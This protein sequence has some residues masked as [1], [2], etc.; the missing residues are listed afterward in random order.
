[1]NLP[2]HQKII[3]I[4]CSSSS[5]LRSK[6]TGEALLNLEQALPFTPISSSEKLKEYSK[7]I[8][9]IRTAHVINYLGFAM[10]ELNMII[11]SV[12][13]LKCQPKIFSP[14]SSETNVSCIVCGSGP[15]LDS[16]I[17]EIKLLSSS[18]I[19]IASGSNYQTLLANNI[20]ADFLCLNE[21]AHDTYSDFKKTYDLYGRTKTKL[22]MSSTCPHR[23]TELFDETAI[24]F[25]P[26]L[27]PLSVFSDSPSEVLS[28][29]GPE[30]VNTGVSF[31]CHIG[32]S[33]IALFG[34]DLGSVSH[35]KIRSSNAS[36]MTPRKF[37]SPRG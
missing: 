16:S 30:A 22:V 24:F 12:D 1:M 4:R 27:T 29:E 31:A 6:I 34:V 21:R 35:E 8:H 28:F 33:T 20:E 5:E 32:A 23:L 14:P 36:G 2:S 18:H 37:I 9:D 15:S 10:D 17:D 3:I 13:T 11:N 25:R 7:D 19:I 26:A